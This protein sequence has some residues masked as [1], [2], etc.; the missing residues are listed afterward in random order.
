MKNEYKTLVESIYKKNGR[1]VLVPEIQP[2]HNDTN[3]H[4]KNAELIV[5]GSQDCKDTFGEYNQWDYG[6][7]FGEI[8]L[9]VIMI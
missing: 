6:D 5:K 9:I 3:S 1:I 2:H 7:S 8:I 4:I